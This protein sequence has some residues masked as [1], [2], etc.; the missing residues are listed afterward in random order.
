MKNKFIQILCIIFTLLVFPIYTYA[1]GPTNPATYEGI[2]VSGWQGY[3]DY[4]RV[5]DSGIDV[6]YIKASQGSDI[7][8]PYFKTN[9]TNAKAN[10][11]SIGL[12]HFLTARS[13][14]DAITE[15]QYFCSV[16][17]GTSPDCKLAMDFEVFG[18]L[19]VE[20]INEISLTFLQEVEELTR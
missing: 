17:S 19:S 12:Y 13:T 18:D 2:D 11:L 1:M 20:E 5:K 16:I 6:V 4:A 3:I 9:Y 14:A 7:T 10:G 15:A 8:D